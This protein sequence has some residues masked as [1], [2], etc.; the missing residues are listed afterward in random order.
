MAGLGAAAAAD[1][2]DTIFE[3][4]AF[5]PLCKLFGAQRIMGSAIDQLRQAGI[6]LHRNE[7]W[8]VLAEPFDMLGHFARSGRAV[9]A[10]DRHVKSTDHRCRGCNVCPD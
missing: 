4:E 9:E 1:Q 6:R 5:E 3:D 7:A 10:D 8:P 2:A